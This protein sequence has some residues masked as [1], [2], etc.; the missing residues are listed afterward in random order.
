MG[1]LGFVWLGHFFAFYGLMAALGVGIGAGIGLT[2]VRRYGLSVNNLILLCACAGLGGI[3][4]SKLLYLLVSLPQLAET[5]WRGALQGGF[6]YYGGI[7]GMLPALRLCQ[8]RLQISIRP[9][10]Q[11]CIGC[12]PV[13]HAIGRVG[14]FLVGCC[15]GR[16]Y[17]GPLC[18][19]YTCSQFA[20]NGVARFPVQLLEA[21][22]ELLI[23]LL[24]LLFSKKLRGMTGFYLYLALYSACR[25][26]L[27][28]LRSDAVRGEI[29][30]LSTSQIL[31]ILL[32]LGAVCLLAKEKI[33]ANSAS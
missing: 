15:Y 17:S 13:G 28:F 3:L 18:V 10:M 7:L 33:P 27:E 4:G 30:I 9:Y 6:V 25:F 5:G 22:V 1:R 16:P 20:P 29:G 24:L 26:F 19:T 32:G 2:Q 23:G 14:C 11:A 31:S 12:L 8:R 21:A